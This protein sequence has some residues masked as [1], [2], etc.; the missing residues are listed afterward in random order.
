MTN[1]PLWE[2]G[3]PTTITRPDDN[4]VCYPPVASP[5]RKILPYGPFFI[6]GI[7]P[8]ECTRRLRCF[9]GI[10]AC[11]RGTDDQLISVL[12]DAESDSAALQRAF[13]M[14]EEL[15]PLPRRKIISVYA[16]LMRPRRAS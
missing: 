7:D 12:R 3:A 4:Q 8:I 14:F 5:A 15:P 1:A 2:S 6:D 9:A 11:H 16:R 13:A 10:V